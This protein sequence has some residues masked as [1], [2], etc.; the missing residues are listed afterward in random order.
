RL[1]VSDFEDDRHDQRPPRGVLHYEAFEVLADLLLDHAVIALLLVT[2]RFER[3]HHRL[4]SLVEETVLAC[5][6]CEPAHHNFGRTLYLAGQLV[7]GD[8]WQHNAVLA[9]V[10][11]IANDEV[12]HHIAH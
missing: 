7:N 5:T 6:G 4:A 3:T 10:S 11:A 8:D 1:C 9:E 12:F 2:R